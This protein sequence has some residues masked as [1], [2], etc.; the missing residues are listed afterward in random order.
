MTSKAPAYAKRV[1]ALFAQF[2]EGFTRI[3]AGV[4]QDA[5]G[6]F[7]PMDNS[8]VGLLFDA[9]ES[10]GLLRPALTLYMD[11]AADPVFAGDVFFRDGRLWTVRKSYGYRYH[12]TTLLVL[13]ACD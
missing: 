9:N 6:L 7:V 12:G 10:V 8:V 5:A 1:T 4:S 3:R 2:S 11:G 13:V